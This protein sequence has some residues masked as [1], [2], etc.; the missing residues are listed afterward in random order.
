[1]F[2]SGCFYGRFEEELGGGFGGFL[3]SA[4]DH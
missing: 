1:M 2:F 3:Y 4:G